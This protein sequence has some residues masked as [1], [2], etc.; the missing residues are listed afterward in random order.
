MENII[1]YYYNL[2]PINFKREGNYYTFFYNDD[3][4]LLVPSIRTKEEMKEVFKT[5]IELKQKNVFPHEIIMN[6]DGNYETNG[7]CLLKIVGYENQEYNL[8]HIF[9][10]N[11][12]LALNETSKKRYINHWVTLWSEKLDYYEYQMSKLNVDKMQ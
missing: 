7:Y 2:K 3:Y 10:F 9:K 8:E 6:R 12:L 4:Y 5:V 1:G 11:K